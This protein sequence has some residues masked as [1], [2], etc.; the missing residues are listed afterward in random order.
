MIKRIGLAGIISAALTSTTAMAGDVRFDG[1]PD[2]NSHLDKIL[3]EYSKVS[4]DVNVTYQMNNHGDHHK[5]LTTNL[6]T[7]SG[8][9]DVVVVDVNFIGSFINAGGFENLSDSAYGAGEMDG[10]FVDYA[11]DQGKGTDGNQYG[12]PI[13]IGPGVSHRRCRRCGQNIH[14]NYG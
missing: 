2:F 8:A 11:W 10:S 6:A 3:P 5:K 9:G 14:L 12:I 13:D 1:F 4:P 7:G